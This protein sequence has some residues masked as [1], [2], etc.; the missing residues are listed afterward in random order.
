MTVRVWQPGDKTV[1]WCGWREKKLQ[2][3]AY[4]R[5]A[6]YPQ[7]LVTPSLRHLSSSHKITWN[8]SG[9]QCCLGEASYPVMDNWQ[10]ALLV[11]V[12]V[13]LPWSAVKNDGPADC[14][15]AL[16][17]HSGGAGSLPTRG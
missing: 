12:P 4:C 9:G 16:S 5:P 8:P 1:Y 11:S 15:L 14:S 2:G 7:A 6:L 10:P 17:V 13:S 3:W